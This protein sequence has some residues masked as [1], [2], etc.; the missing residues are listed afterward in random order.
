[1]TDDFKGIKMPKNIVITGATG[2][3]GMALVE[4]CIKE[5]CNI[6]VLARK[7]SDR[8]KFLSGISN[9]I[10]VLECDLEGLK[11]LDILD[12][13]A[14]C[15]YNILYHLAWMGTFGQS[16]NNLDLQMM[17]VQYSLD[18]VRLAAKLGCDTFIGVGS[19]AEYGRVQGII[20]E[21]IKTNPENGYGVAKLCASYMTRLLCKELGLKYAWTRVLSVYGPYDRQETM[22]M[23]SL[24]KMLKNEDTFYTAGEQ[25]W[26][27]LFS[28]DAASALYMIGCNNSNPADDL[29]IYCLGSGTA[30]QLKDYIMDMKNISGTNGNVN[31]GSI[32][33]GDNQVMNLVV[34]ISKL[35]KDTGFEPKYSFAEGIL[36]TIDWIKINEKN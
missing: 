33:Y 26:D 13:K 5:D 6:L 25:M 24:N 4:K 9:K 19:Q 3:I 10:K 36:K 29:G 32:P 7:G 22:V 15:D 34:D 28:E 8:N 21:D 35:K 1:M 27:Y 23:S 12:I 2:A 17:N 14:E 30:R 31:L 16:R 11:A 20:S 18:A